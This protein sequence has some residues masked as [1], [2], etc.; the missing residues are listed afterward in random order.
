MWLGLLALGC[1]RGGAGEPQ[2]TGKAGE[3]STLVAPFDLARVVAELA[4]GAS[5]RP[6]LMPESEAYAQLRRGA[7]DGELRQLLRHP[8]PVVRVYAFQALADHHPDSALAAELSSIVGDVSEVWLGGAGPGKSTVAELALERVESRLAGA[9]RDAIAAQ[10]LTTRSPTRYA[11]R[12]RR[13]WTFSRALH[14]PLRALARDGDGDVLPALARYRDPADIPLLAAALREPTAEYALQAIAEFPDAS[15]VGPLREL[16][17]RLLAARIQRSDVFAMSSLPAG[18][19]RREP[20]AQLLCAFYAAA[21]RFPPPVAESFLAAPFA[22]RP[23]AQDLAAH[24]TCQRWVLQPELIRQHATAGFR[25]WERHG[26]LQLAQLQVLWAADT[27]RARRLAQESAAELGQFEPDTVAWLLEQTE[28]AERAAALRGL[29]SGL[30]RAERQELENLCEAIRKLQ[31]RE[32]LPELFA[33]LERSRPLANAEM[34]TFQQELTRPLVWHI[35]RW[36]LSEPERL[37]LVTWV[38][39]GRAARERDTR[40]PIGQRI[41]EDYL[42]DVLSRARLLTPSAV[43]SAW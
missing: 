24:V 5:Q 28:G 6:T 30:R 9:E 1:E 12:M 18:V 38:V 26:T 14:E 34:A 21:L 17:Q 20:D 33:L 35:S 27:A 32:L 16:Q 40:D 39:G 15:F 43:V 11:A 36:Q 23:Q 4:G 2:P 3:A 13:E 31:L 41:V 29:R 25:L 22:R 10:L 42:V 37:R 19:W 8:S 7:S